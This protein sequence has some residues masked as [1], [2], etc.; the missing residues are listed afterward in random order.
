MS[1]PKRR[2]TYIVTSNNQ[3]SVCTDY[4]GNSTNWLGSHWRTLRS[5]EIAHLWF[6]RDTGPQ[7][8]V[9]PTLCFFVFFVN[10]LFSKRKNNTSNPVQ[11]T[12]SLQ[13]H[14]ILNVLFELAHDTN[15]ILFFLFSVL[16][17]VTRS[18]CVE[19]I[20]DILL[21][22]VIFSHLFI[23]PYFCFCLGNVF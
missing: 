4:S 23:W 19:H 18:Q 17:I 14:I 12:T 11:S 6:D 21:Y 3:W 2:G 20:N 9:E 8:G 7:P 13:R 10:S 5:P 16:S 15:Y 1:K 22:I